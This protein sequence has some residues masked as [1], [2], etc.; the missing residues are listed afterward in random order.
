M[1][2][3]YDLIFFD[4]DETLFDYRQ[5]SKYAFIDTLSRYSYLDQDKCIA[6]FEE[7]EKINDAL[8]IKYH[9]GE[10]E[11]ATLLHERFETLFKKMNLKIDSEEFNSKY[12]VNLSYQSF[13]MPNAEIVIKDLFNYCKLVIITNGVASVHE[14]RLKSSPIN[15]FISEIFVS[16]N[17]G[18]NS[19]YKKPNALFFQFAHQQT[20]PNIPLDRILMVGDSILSDIGGGNAYG[21]DTCWYN[22]KKERNELNILPTYEIS[23]LYGLLELVKEEV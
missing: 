15:Q 8:W 19:N 4:S 23:D 10:I 12:L 5:C 22:S 21:I 7:Y 1:A 3:K 13:M 16:G 18:N 14:N 20:L 11:K 2:A 6:A 9:N 17:Y